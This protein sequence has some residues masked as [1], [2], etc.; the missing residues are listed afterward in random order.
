MTRIV[1]LIAG[2]TLIA[3]ACASVSDTSEDTTARAVAE[4]GAQDTERSLPPASGAAAEENEGGTT[5]S[6]G[7]LTEAEESV[8]PTTAPQGT[9]DGALQ[10][11]I[12]VAISDLASRLSVAS[13]DIDVVSAEVVVWPDSSLGCPQSGM[14][15][16]QVLSEGYQVVLARGGTTY[17]YHGGEG[18]G[19]FLC[20]KK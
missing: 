9:V 3:C 14:S 20:T 12:D 17:S 16:L 7:D 4:A 8:E 2:L 15:Y 19:P 1:V 11:L 18:Q 10:S 13:G 6:T 5:R